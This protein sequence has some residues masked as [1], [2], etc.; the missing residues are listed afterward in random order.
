M[1]KVTRKCSICKEKID[2]LNSNEDFFISV[3]NGSRSYTHSSCYIKYHTSSKRRKQK[4]VQECNAFIE[5]C[6]LKNKE[7]EKNKYIKEM[8]YA[9][10]SDMYNISFFPNYFYIKMDSIYKGTYKNLNKPVPPEYLLDMWQQKKVYL[11]KVAEQNRKKGIEMNGISRFNY[12]LVILLSRYDS[13]LKWKEQQKIAATD[14]KEQKNKSVE[15]IEYKDVIRPQKQIKQNDKINI[16]S[17]I[18]EI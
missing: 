4:T 9:F 12:D 3:K 7:L 11:E 6:K 1:K 18:D 16:S 8:L 13:Y 14:F 5:Q 15:K 2:V 17:M 10:L